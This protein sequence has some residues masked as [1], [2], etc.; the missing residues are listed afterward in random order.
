LLLAGSVC[1]VAN[2]FRAFVAGRIADNVSAQVNGRTDV[3]GLIAGLCIWITRR[4]SR[5]TAKG[6]IAGLQTVTEHAV[7]ANQRLTILTDSGLAGF[8][9]VADSVICTGGAV[10]YVLR[11]ADPVCRIALI[12]RASVAGIRAGDVGA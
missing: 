2:I 1:G 5:L 8:L 3:V 9:T 12:D 11:L 6:R 4:C 10:R 7:V